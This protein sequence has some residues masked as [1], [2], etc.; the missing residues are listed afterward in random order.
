[1]PIITIH[2]YYIIVGIEEVERANSDAARIDPA[3]RGDQTFGSVELA[4][5][6][7]DAC[8]RDIQTHTACNTLVTVNG[9]SA[10]KILDAYGKYDSVKI[11][12]V[13]RK[14]TCGQVEEYVSD[15]WKDIGEGDLEEMALSDAGLKKI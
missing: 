8:S 2:R 6:D 14:D 7:D 15:K 13:Q 5:A 9:G 10:S 3:P 4:P 11:Y 12:R 1:M